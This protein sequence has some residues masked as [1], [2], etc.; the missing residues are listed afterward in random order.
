MHHDLDDL[1]GWLAPLIFDISPHWMANDARIEN[2]DLN[3]G[4]RYQFGFISSHIMPSQNR[5]IIWHSK[6]ML[7]GTITGVDFCWGNANEAPKGQTLLFFL[8]LITRLCED[9]GVPFWGK[10]VQIT[11]ASSNDIHRI[12][13]VFLRDDAARRK[14]PPPDTTPLVYP[15]TL[16][17][18]ATIFSPSMELSGIHMAPSAPSTSTVASPSPASI[19]RPP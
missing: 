13:A 19:Y 2:K 9:A 3:V 10:D 15:T 6:A 4:A 11:P 18:E 8:V 7:V 1:K 5:S 12:E 16:A 17:S 14:P